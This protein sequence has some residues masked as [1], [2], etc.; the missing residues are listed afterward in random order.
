V[1][2]AEVVVEFRQA[3]ERSFAIR[4]T[5]PTR[6]LSWSRLD[7]SAHAMMEAADAIERASDY[8]APDSSENVAGLAQWCKAQAKECRDNGRPTAS[9]AY[10]AI[11]ARLEQVPTG[12]SHSYMR[13]WH[14]LKGIGVTSGSVHA[15][16]MSVMMEKVERDYPVKLEL[17]T[18]VDDGQPEPDV[19]SMTPVDHLVAAD[20]IYASMLNHEF[21]AQVMVQQAAMATM[22]AAMA[23]AKIAQQ[24]GEVT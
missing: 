17:H 15:V 13:R 14:E 9:N 6:E 18:H 24:Y 3:A 16:W 2:L 1:N 20:N 4:N 10:Y 7:A 12:E 21:T 19:A 22:H 11:A 23:H 5:L 8:R